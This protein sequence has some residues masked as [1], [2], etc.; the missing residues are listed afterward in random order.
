MDRAPRLH[1]LARAGYV[2]RGV[3]FLILGYFTALAAS[4]ATS[5]TIDGKEA[6]NKV[7]AQPLGRLLLAVM[8]IGLLC[9]GLWR[10]TQCLIDPDGYGRDAKG[11]TRRGIYGLAGLFYI[12]FAAVAMAM[13]VGVATGDTDSSIRDWTAW[14]LAK[15]VGQWLI[16]AIGLIVLGSGIGTG[17]SG[18]RAEFKEQLALSKQPRRM[19]TALGCIGFLT[20]AFVFA[21]IGVF[22]IFAAIDSNAHEATGFAG[23]L[24]IVKQYPHGTMLLALVAAGLFAFGAFGIAEAAFRRIDDKSVWWGVQS[25]LH[26]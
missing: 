19:V 18:I 20:R 3:V 11:W 2:A 4:G 23:A 9:F 7:L 25:W 13:V 6:L 1:W 24:M 8:A 16:G 26:V 5:R 22:L 10:T 17:V 15:P 12:G 21:I 14:L